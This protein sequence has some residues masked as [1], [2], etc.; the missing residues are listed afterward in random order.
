M[1][2]LLPPLT[3]LAT[4]ALGNFARAETVSLSASTS[5][6]AHA[7]ASGSG[8]SKPVKDDSAEAPAADAAAPNA[9]TAPKQAVLEL[10]LFGGVY[11]PSSQHRLYS[12]THEAFDSPAPDLGGRIAVFPVP[13]LGLEVE[14]A[15]IPIKTKN[16]DSKGGLWAGRVHL[17]G[18]LPLGSLS[19]FALGGGGALGGG[20]VVTGS[21][22]D[23]EMH[24]GLGAKYAL[25]EV[26]GLRLDLRDTFIQKNNASQG[27][28]TQ[29]PEV[30]LGIAFSVRPPRPLPPPPPP[31]ADGDGVPDSEDAC[32]HVAG[33]KPSGCP[34]TDG[35]GVT[36]DKDACVNEKGSAPC[37]C[38]PRDSDGDKV[39]DE[40][41]R[42]PNE[43]G[44]IE[45]CPDPDPDHDG[46]LGAQDR[47][48]N[49]PE[50]KNGFQDDDGCPDELPER[51][52]QFTGVIKGIE[53]DRGTEKIRPI[54]ASALDG[55]ASVLNEFVALRVLITG[56]TDSDGNRDFNLDLSRRRAE[57]VKAYL[58]GKGI[59]EDR[60]ETRGAGPDE[61]I[62]DNKTA[63]G[64]QKNRRIEFKLLEAKSTAPKP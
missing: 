48:P 10:G 61:P 7:D 54:S 64:K 39:I 41:D 63:A 20:T 32:V 16:T 52:K 60:I 4:L 42:C 44:P 53:F 3:V 31:D 28:L 50:T 33:L 18:Q 30:L 51:V 57:S 22:V 25:D 13:V 49:E 8:A 43:P 59:S 15:G 56:H 12:L 27:T 58:V 40:L 11:F 29:N 2:R 36:D 35:D 1:Q 45:G 34:D 23:P 5:N 47:C 17:I 14:A 46:I 55:A 9:D 26:V 21:D 38:P 37:G 19:L 24:F 6:G 62:A